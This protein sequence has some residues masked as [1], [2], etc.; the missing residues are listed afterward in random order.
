[1]RWDHLTA[2]PDQDRTPTAPELP[3]AIRGATVRTFDT[4]GFR[5]M[6][7]YEIQAKSIIN[8]VP[9]GSRV[10]FRWT[11]NPYR[12]C[13]HA[14]VYC[15]SGDTRILMAD[16]STKALADLKVGDEICG[17]VMEG[18]RRRYIA[19][20]VLDHWSTVKPAYRVTLEDGTRLVT[21]GEHRFLTERGWV[22]VADLDGHLP[23]LT[24]DDV[25]VGTGRFADPPEESDAYRRGY[26]CGL[27]RGGGHVGS[28]GYGRRGHNGGLAHRLRSA[29]VEPAA[30]RR[31]RRY[32]REFEAVDSQFLFYAAVPAGAGA[33]RRATRGATRLAGGDDRRIRRLI[34]WPP[35]PTPQWYAGFLA[36]VYDA[37]GSFTGRTLAIVHSD[38]E[39]RAWVLSALNDLGFRPGAVDPETFGHLEPITVDGGFAEHLRF[40]QSVDPA[41]S[42]KRDIGARGI[43]VTGRL[44][45]VSVEP[46][47]MELPL[48]DITT[49]TGDFIANGVVSHNCF[50]RHSHTYLDLDTGRDFDTRV[51]VKVNAGELLR[52]ELAMPRWRGEPIAMG[53]N[54]D[55]YQ[56]AEGRYALMPPIL[57]TLRDFAN[58]FSILTKGTLILRDLPLLRQ[59]AE[60]TQVELAVSVGFL[61]KTLWRSVEPGTPSPERRL[62]VVTAL[63][64]AGLSCEVLLAP[65][66]PGL[67]DSDEQLEHTIRAIAQAGASRVIPLVLHLRPGAREWYRTWLA[68]EHPHLLPRYRQLYGRGSYAEASYQR[69]LTAKVHHIARRYG[70]NRAEQERTRLTFRATHQPQARPDPAPRQLDLFSIS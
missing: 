51:V 67:T 43:E 19:T 13:S 36:G 44:G 14:C 47:G 64:E 52:R 32:L 68:R 15:L 21:S 53:T 16:G 4:P 2:R 7:F 56:R 25:L 3:L 26:L 48:F 29:M 33:Q 55:C 58:P 62:E 37:V 24:C 27:I 31:A 69:N 11:V 54:V 8:K 12:G 20:Q 10:P 34:Q 41:S 45:V 65:I 66:L 1:M 50:A 23:A 40:L 28:P 17:T 63:T 59:A 30:L 61:D 57:E 6:T 39:I 22:H 9:E 42:R 18:T 46:L 70:L 35:A 49:G 60:V 5:G 38:P